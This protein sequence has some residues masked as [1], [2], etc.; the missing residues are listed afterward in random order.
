MLT[1]YLHKGGID[2]YQVSVGKGV[3]GIRVDKAASGALGQLKPFKS[4]GKKLLIV[5]RDLCLHTRK[6]YPPASYSDL[7]KAIQ[8][9]IEDIFPIKDPSYFFK[10]F[11][12]TSAYT[13]VDLWAWE[14][15]EINK[16]KT[17]FPFTH[18]MPEDAAF[19]SDK[20]EIS[21]LINDGIASIVAYSKNGFMGSAVIKDITRQQIEIFLKGIGRHFEGIKRASIYN[22]PDSRLAD[23]LKPLVP[24]VLNKQTWSYPV[25]IDYTDRL[26][27]KDFR[28]EAGYADILKN[29]HTIMR[30]SLYILIALSVSLFTTSRNYDSSLKEINKKISRV[31]VDAAS[32]ASK[33]AGEDYRDAL[34]ELDEKLKDNMHPFKIMDMLAQ[35]LPDR[36]YVTRIVLNEKNLEL[37]IVSKEP[38][39]VIKAIGQSEMVN[40]IKLRGAPMKDPKGIYTFSVVAE[41]K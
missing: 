6:K 17:I 30:F 11:E 34:N 27:L 32:L 2:I 9:D 23:D 7:K 39:N 37:S 24:E 22:A 8:M 28:I 3:S 12:K 19:I 33:A 16:I 10:I 41:L 14:S 38:L 36:S 29:I 15:S 1:A 31:S 13:L 25:C 18:I 40:T 21:I 20:P 35:R 4:L 26:N 5:G